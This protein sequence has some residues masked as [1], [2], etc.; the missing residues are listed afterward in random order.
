MGK[1]SIRIGNRNVT[2]S[3]LDKVLYPSG[4]FTKS[5]VIEYYV[6]AGRFLLPHFKN[7]P[8]TL[9]RYPDGVLG[10]SFYEKQAPTFTPDWITTFPVPR[11]EGGVIHYILINNLP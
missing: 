6:H 7:R 8:V 4:N 2:V 3:N 5:Q 1:S 10:K 11:I 9:V